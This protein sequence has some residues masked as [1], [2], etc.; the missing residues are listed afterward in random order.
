MAIVQNEKIVELV[1]NES[2]KIIVFEGIN[3]CGKGTQINKF[4]LNF[5]VQ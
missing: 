5:M 2:R 1:E 3:G 4:L